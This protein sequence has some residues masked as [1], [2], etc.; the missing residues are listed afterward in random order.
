MVYTKFRTYKIPNSRFNVVNSELCKATGFPNALCVGDCMVIPPGQ[1]VRGYVG[2]YNLG[3]R[4]PLFYWTAD[5]LTIC[6]PEVIALAGT[7]RHNV[8]AT[9]WAWIE[10]AIVSVFNGQLVKSGDGMPAHL[11]SNIC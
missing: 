1:P 8:E 11:P 10:K 2:G 6:I 7:S 5:E 9:F 4:T 3:Q